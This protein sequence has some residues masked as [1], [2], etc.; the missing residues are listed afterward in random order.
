MN[1]AGPARWLR[2]LAV[3]AAFAAW[4]LAAH[5]AS[6]G[7]TGPDFAVALG[8]APGVAALALLR[9]HPGWLAA[10][11]LAT[12]ALLAALWPLLRTQ[13]ALLYLLQHVGTLLALAAL[14]GRSLAGPGDALV[15]RIARTLEGTLSERKVRYTRGV[16]LAWTL[17]FIAGA[18]TSL[19][20][21]AL[22]PVA[23]WSAFANLATA[24]LVGLMFVAEHLWRMAVL[25]PEERP[26]LASVI[27]AWRAHRDLPASPT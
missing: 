9:R 12:L 19:L 4:A 24:P 20:L 1:A 26:S 25:P 22:A 7:L 23:V 3:A 2:G 18:T 10:A 13:P 6:A 17:F 5:L 15:T 11:G 21:Y 27:R 16:T 8:V 14:F